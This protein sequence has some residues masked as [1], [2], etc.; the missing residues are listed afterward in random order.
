MSPEDLRHHRTCAH[1]TQAVR[2]GC[3]PVSRAGK[4]GS[5]GIW[6]TATSMGRPSTTPN[7]LHLSRVGWG[8]CPSQEHEC[9]G[10]QPG[11]RLRGLR[12]AHLEGRVG[13][14]MQAGPLL[15]LDLMLGDRTARPLG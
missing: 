9:R 12:T 7:K 10:T 11:L 4:V 14:E 3:G 6:V 13:T 2:R 1:V 15:D 8:Q 5:G